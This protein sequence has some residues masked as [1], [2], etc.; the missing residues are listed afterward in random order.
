M[1]ANTFVHKMSNK[2]EII[3]PLKLLT[4]NRTKIT[5]VERGSRGSNQKETVASAPTTKRFT[6][7]LPISVQ[8]KTRSTN[9]TSAQ[10]QSANGGQTL[11]TTPRRTAANARGPRSRDAP[12]ASRRQQNK[13]PNPTGLP[14]HTMSRD[15]LFQVLRCCCGALPT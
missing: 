7:H 1:T 12:V 3:F 15:I 6:K 4:A 9:G 2:S 13:R 10:W 11:K 5:Q 14:C 8:R